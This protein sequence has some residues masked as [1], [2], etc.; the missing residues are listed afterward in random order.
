MIIV[1]IHYFRQYNS[2]NDDITTGYDV[3]WDGS[4]WISSFSNGV[5]QI[6]KNDG[7]LI[8]QSS[9]NNV[10]GSIVDDYFN[11]ALTINNNSFVSIGNSNPTHRLTISGTSNDDKGPHIAFYTDD[12]SNYPLY[13]QYN[14]EHDNINQSYDQFYDGSNWISCHNF[15]NFRI[16]KSNHQLIV[17]SSCNINTGTVISTNNPSLVINNDG[18]LGIGTSNCSFKISI[19]G[20]SN[21]VK[22]PH[23]TCYTDDDVNY[24]LFQQ[25]NIEHGL[26]STNYDL[27]WD[28]SNYISSSYIA[29]YQIIKNGD[30]FSFRVA[31]NVLPGN[32]L[33]SSLCNALT[34]SK[35]G[36]VNLGGSNPQYRF[37]MIG[38]SND[39]S[40]PHTAFYVN[41]DSN[42]PLYF[43]YNSDHDD[44]HTGYDTYYDGSNWLSCSSNG[45]FLQSKSSSSLT[46][47][48]ANSVITNREITWQPSFTIANDGLIGIRNINPQ[49]SLTI[50]GLE[51]SI[52]GPHIVAYTMDDDINPLWCQINID[53]NNINTGYDTYWNGSNWINSSS[54]GSF[55][56]MKSQDRLIICS[57]S[58]QVPG[59]KNQ[60]FPNITIHDNGF[61]GFGTEN[62]LNRLTI[63]GP[64][65]SINGPHLVFYVDEDSNYPIYQQLNNYHDD[66]CFNFDQYWDG[67]NIISS[68]ING[69]YQIIKSDRLFSM[70]VSDNNF[71]GCNIESS[72]L[73]YSVNSCGNFGINTSNQTFN[74]EVAGQ[75][76]I[77][78]NCNLGL[79]NP[80]F[81]LMSLQM[82]DG[83]T[84]PPPSMRDI[85]TYSESGIYNISG[86]F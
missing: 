75:F 45:N 40:G 27:F 15:G 36:Y 76:M 49:Y 83:L 53:H 11:P 31:K 73:A 48:Y 35:N 77:N 33:D 65:S 71:P 74:L 72:N 81:D 7:K 26:I 9:E 4:N 44:I 46:Y 18:L 51:N 56:M 22:G 20:S 47:Y 86:I 8:I 41:Y 61:V 39:I 3:F 80:N 66:I 54:N 82:I 59:T 17:F 85:F 60:W 14:V 34:I 78:T 30:S 32:Q 58:N 24:P 52:L 6:K 62:P 25:T 2:R 55:L 84:I 12:D 50:K 29:N 1:I 28:G 43:Q 68:S 5:F 13:Q 42:N 70:F 10:L 16:S 21:S 67:S 37:T 63:N 79:S 57:S 19:S 64:Q 38:L 69:N 23:I